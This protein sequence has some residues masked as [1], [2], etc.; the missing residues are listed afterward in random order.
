M[1]FL[2]ERLGRIFARNVVPAVGVSI[3]VVQ[4]NS[5]E[6]TVYMEAAGLHPAPEAIN[7]NRY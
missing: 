3:N 5:G 7:L 4:E 6:A 2:L 1:F